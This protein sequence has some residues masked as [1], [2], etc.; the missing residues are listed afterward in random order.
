LSEIKGSA[1]VEQVGSIGL[2][3]ARGNVD[4]RKHQEVNIDIDKLYGSGKGP[5]QWR[6]V[7]ASNGVLQEVESENQWSGS[8]SLSIH[9]MKGPI[10]RSTGN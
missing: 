5:L 4:L 1:D 8:V 9:L 7:N 3:G 2:K 10:R 6:N